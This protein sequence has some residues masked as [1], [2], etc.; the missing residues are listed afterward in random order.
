MS[1][2][3]KEAFQRA[4]KSPGQKMWS[5]VKEATWKKPSPR[6]QIQP[7]GRLVNVRHLSNSSQWWSSNKGPMLTTGSFSLGTEAKLDDQIKIQWLLKF[8]SDKK[9]LVHIG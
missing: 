8:N 7:W 1:V 6:K 5:Q 3:E 4:R 9:V 2:Y